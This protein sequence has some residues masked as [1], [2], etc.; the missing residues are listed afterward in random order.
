MTTYNYLGS[1][2]SE[3]PKLYFYRRNA[4][5]KIIFW[6]QYDREFGRKKSKKN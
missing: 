4:V 6:P 1:L 5:E 2:D 3:K